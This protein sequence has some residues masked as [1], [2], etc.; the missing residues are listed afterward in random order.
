MDGRS[1]VV[2]SEYTIRIESLAFPPPLYWIFIDEGES[3]SVCGEDC[4][5]CERGMYICIRRK[6]A[7][8]EKKKRTRGKKVYPTD[9]QHHC[10][11]QRRK[12]TAPEN[13]KSRGRSK[14]Y[15]FWESQLLIY[16][17]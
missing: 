9:N 13:V 12:V 4:V 17:R 1:V 7:M 11:T 15:V 3:C 14:Y 6:T 5:E 16:L 8:R 2:G 10:K